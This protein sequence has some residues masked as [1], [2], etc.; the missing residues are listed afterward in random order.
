MVRWHHHHRLNGHEFEQDLGDSEEQGSLAC[1]SPC[2]LSV[3][4]SRSLLKLMSIESVMRS[5]HLILCYRLLLLPSIFPSIRVF[6]S[7]VGSSH[8]VAKVLELQHQSFQIIFRVDFLISISTIIYITVSLDNFFFPQL[9]PV[10]RG[11]F[12]P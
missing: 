11:S 3:T 8:Q 10:G 1:C 4:I 12:I 9:Q 5:N 6:L 7:R 2:S